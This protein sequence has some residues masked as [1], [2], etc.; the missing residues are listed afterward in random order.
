MACGQDDRV[1]GVGGVTGA[2]PQQIGRGTPTAVPDPALP[3]VVHPG[4][5][6]DARQ[7][8][9][10]ILGKPHRR[11]PH[12]VEAHRWGVAAVHAQNLCQQRADTGGQWRARRRGAPAPPERPGVRPGHPAIPSSRRCVLPSSSQLVVGGDTTYTF[13]G[14]VTA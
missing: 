7:G 11:Q 14:V 1:R 5:A 6:D 4:R 10:R 8:R 9:A 13:T 12:R 3:V 2:Q